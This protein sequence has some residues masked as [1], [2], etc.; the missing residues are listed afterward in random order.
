[1]PLNFLP[2]QLNKPV[3]DPEDEG[4]LGFLK[5][6]FAQFGAS[7]TVTAPQPAPPELRPPTPAQREQR[8]T[9]SFQPRVINNILGG[10]KEKSDWEYVLDSFRRGGSSFAHGTKQFFTTELPQMFASAIANNP[11][12]VKAD[13]ELYAKAQEVLPRLQEKYKRQEAAHQN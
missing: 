12:N 13:P 9:P 11:Q 10:E 2:R 5:D 8:Q 6:K 3:E 4:F 1:M 7:D